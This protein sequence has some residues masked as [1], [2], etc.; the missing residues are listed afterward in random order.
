[1]PCKRDQTPP[2]EVSCLLSIEAAVD[3]QLIYSRCPLSLSSLEAI[4]SSSSTLLC[5]VQALFCIPIGCLIFSLL[6]HWPIGF[7]HIALGTR[8]TRW[9]LK[10]IYWTLKLWIN[11]TGFTCTLWLLFYSLLENNSKDLSTLSNLTRRPI[12]L[13]LVSE[14]GIFLRYWD[15]LLFPVYIYAPTGISRSLTD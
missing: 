8:F 9:T 13:H 4:A 2:W 11:S 15:Y 1:M 14:V 3:I 12:L 5:A 6:Y 10:L 7:I